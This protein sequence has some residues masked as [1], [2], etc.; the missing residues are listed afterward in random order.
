M[1]SSSMWQRFQQLFLRYDDIG[2]S[3]DLSQMNFPEGFFDEK[4]ALIDKAFGSMRELEGG[5]IA[6]PDDG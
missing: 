1:G 5:A 4:R 2:F 6:N 3:I